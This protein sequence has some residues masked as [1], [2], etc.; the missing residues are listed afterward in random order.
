MTVT[1]LGSAATTPADVIATLTPDAERM[2]AIVCVVLMEDGTWHVRHS[3][4]QQSIVDS[5]AINLMKFVTN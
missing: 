5:A 3:T 1:R 4:T 2:R